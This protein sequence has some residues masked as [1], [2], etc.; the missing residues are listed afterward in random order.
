MWVKNTG[1]CLRSLGFTSLPGIGL[2]KMFFPHALRAAW[3]DLAA[4]QKGFYNSKPRSQRVLAQTRRQVEMTEAM[5]EKD[6]VRN[7]PWQLSSRVGKFAVNP[8][9]VRELVSGK[10]LSCLEKQWDSAVR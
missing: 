6:P 2:K 1:L 3:N 5:D 9:V 8:S 4:D 7:G 10:S